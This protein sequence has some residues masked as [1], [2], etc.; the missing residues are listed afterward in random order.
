MLPPAV[1]AIKGENRYNMD[2]ARIMEGM[3]DNGLVVRSA[4]KR[5]IQKKHPGSKAWTSFIK[6]INATGRALHPLVIWKGK[7]VQQQWF[8]TI[9]K[10]FKGWEFTT[11]DNGWTTD[12]TATEWLVKCFLPQTALRDL[13]ERRLLILDGHG[14]YETTE[15]MWLCFLHNVYLVYLPSYT[16]HVLQLSYGDILSHMLWCDRFMPE[17]HFPLRFYIAYVTLYNK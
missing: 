7:S 1:K 8:K 10:Q 5:F 14:S 17:P 3:G 4:N 12:D 9:L 16:S 13:S 11:T 15:F 2:E 6:C